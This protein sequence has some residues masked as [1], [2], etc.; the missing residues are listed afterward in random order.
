M[1]IINIRAESKNE[2]GEI[3]PAPE[4]LTHAGPIIPATLTLSD[5][6]QRVYTEKGEQPPEAVNGYAMI[7]TGASK[8]CV[9]QTCAK[10]AG[11]PVVGT[12]KMASA[13]QSEIA[14]PVFAGKITLAPTNIVIKVEN[15][16]GANLSAFNGLVALI[17]RDLLQSASFFY[18]GPDGFISLSI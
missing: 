11:L 12:A 16:L 15:G 8:T 2:K 13:T 14:V 17:G 6:T 10:K 5:E 3:H 4:A 7:D 18:N 1:P 9:D